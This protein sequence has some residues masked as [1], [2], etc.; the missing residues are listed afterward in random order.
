MNKALYFK[1]FQLLKVMI[2]RKGCFG[3]NFS[4][5]SLIAK[6]ASSNAHAT[7]LFYWNIKPLSHWAMGPTTFI[8]VGSFCVDEERF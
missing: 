5:L 1:L 6:K 2:V 8:G 3:W 4:I 7:G